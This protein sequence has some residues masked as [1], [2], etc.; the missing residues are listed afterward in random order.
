MPKD[1][2]DL[3]LDQLERH[4]E[5]HLRQRR[6]QEKGEDIGGQEAARGEELQWQ[7]GILHASLDDDEA[8]ERR[9]ADAECRQHQGMP[10]SEGPH[11]ARRAA[12]RLGPRRLQASPPRC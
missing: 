7:H 4:E 2:N 9:D 11:S 5:Q 8:D 12:R 3:D 1:I 6:V 10:R